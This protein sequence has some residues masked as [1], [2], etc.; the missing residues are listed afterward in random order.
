M[1]NVLFLKR[2]NK[3]QLEK[4]DIVGVERLKFFYYI[5]DQTC[6]TPTMCCFLREKTKKQPKNKTLWVEVV[7]GVRRQFNLL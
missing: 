3:K 6:S 5:I 2:K 7:G 4:K 1:T